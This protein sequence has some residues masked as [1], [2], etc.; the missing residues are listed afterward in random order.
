MTERRTVGLA[1]GTALLAVLVGGATWLALEPTADRTDGSCDTAYVEL[2]AEPDDGVVEV[3]FD[4]TSNA[5]GEAWHI[6]VERD[7]RVVHETD[8]RTDEDA[9]IE[10]DLVQEP[11][12]DQPLSV[13]ATREGGTPCVATLGRD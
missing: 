6:V 8:R 13:T 5:P 10:V 3:E 7:G 4:L 1:G 12:A 11:G 9:E 2:A